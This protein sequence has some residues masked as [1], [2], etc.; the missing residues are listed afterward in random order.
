MDTEDS[1]EESFI[2]SLT[3]AIPED[4]EKPVYNGSIK[5][6]ETGEIIKTDLL[7]EKSKTALFL[8]ENSEEYVKAKGT[9]WKA[10][11]TKEK[12]SPEELKSAIIGG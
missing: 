11:S 9:D 2:S 7:W 8:G 4:R 5:I 1:E 12:F 10:F 6:I 3:F